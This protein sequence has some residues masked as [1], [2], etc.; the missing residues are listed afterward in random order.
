MHKTV[1]GFSKLSKE[2]KIDWI[3]QNCTNDPE[4]TKKLLGQYWNPDE[5]LQK[6]HDELENKG[7]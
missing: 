2:E 7:F 3:A 5:G 4:A 1:E 6:I